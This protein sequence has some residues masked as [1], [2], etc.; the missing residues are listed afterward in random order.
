MQLSSQSFRNGI[1]IPAEFAFGRIDPI[2]HFGG[3]AFNH[4]FAACAFASIDMSGWFSS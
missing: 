1:P 3:A 2:H 4:L